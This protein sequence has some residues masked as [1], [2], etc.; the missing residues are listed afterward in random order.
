MDAQQTW[1]QNRETQGTLPKELGKI[2]KKQSEIKS[3]ITEMKT[4][5]EGINIRFVKKEEWI[6]N[7][8]DRIVEMT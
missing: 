6:N 8:E 2:I 7:L 5:S 3:T 4:T 1:Q